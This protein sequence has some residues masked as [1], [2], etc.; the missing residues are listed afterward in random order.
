[1]ESKTV[2]GYI[3]YIAKEAYNSYCSHTNYKS[4]ATGADLP[5]WDD[6]EEKYIDAWHCV[7]MTLLDL[8]SPE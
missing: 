5:Q 1:M 3:E 4:L 2:D 8:L 6:L 7:A